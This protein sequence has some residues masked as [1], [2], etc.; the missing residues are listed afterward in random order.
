MLFCSLSFPA[1]S[2]SA[3]SAPA[4]ISS[5]E[6]ELKNNGETTIFLGHVILK[7]ENYEIH[8]NRMIRTKSTG[9]VDAK[10]HVIA[11]WI[12]AKKEKIQVFGD[13]ARYQPALNT[14]DVWGP[15]RV[16]VQLD[17][18]KGKAL[19]HGDKG[20]VSTLQPGKATLTGQVTGHITPL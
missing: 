6:L 11:T 3:S 17:G 18:E 2:W 7:Q 10:G 13:E 1:L 14:V 16:D 20:W 15:H 4:T 9:I 8:A 5:D 12:S 19:F